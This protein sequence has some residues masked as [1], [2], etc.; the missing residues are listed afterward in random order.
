MYYFI[1]RYKRLELLANSSV[2]FSTVNFSA[3]HIFI[4]I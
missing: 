2:Y 3:I 4:N 1:L